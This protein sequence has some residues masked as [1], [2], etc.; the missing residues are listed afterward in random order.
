M[1][2]DRYN[3]ENKGELLIT[4][5]AFAL[6][7][8]FLINRQNIEFVS[9]LLASVTF[10]VLNIILKFHILRLSAER[11]LDE[12][13]IVKEKI[14][15]TGALY[16]LVIKLNLTNETGVVGEIK[17]ENEK[18]YSLDYKLENLPKNWSNTSILNEL[19]FYLFS[20]ALGM[21]LIFFYIN[22]VS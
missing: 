8:N 3:E 7:V 13:K 6:L 16:S 10:L 18:L 9:L 1:A 2:D 20:I 19:E 22:L 14:N 15:V 17:K 21:M 11:V 12:L 4:T 5:G